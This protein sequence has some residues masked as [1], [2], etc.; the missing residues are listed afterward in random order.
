M[1]D[2]PTA[3]KHYSDLSVERLKGSE[4]ELTGDIPVE[5]ARTFVRKAI[6]AA[7]QTLELPG[8]RKG[9]VPEDMVRAHVGEMALLQDAAERALAA[10]YPEMVDEHKLEVVGRPAVTITKLVPGN[11]IGFKIKSALYPTVELPN[12]SKLAAQELKKHD[13]P[14]TVEIDDAEIAT[15]LERLQKML[16]QVPREGAADD[17][18]SIESG[19]QKE[20]ELPPLS[21]DFAK[22]LGDFKDLND[23]KEKIKVG[24]LN[25][26]K[27]KAHEK[28]RLA[29][30]DAIIAKSR[31]EVPEIF[32]EGELDQMLASFEERVTRAGMKFEEYLV[33]AKKTKEDLRNEWRAD[34]EKRAKLQLIFNEIAKKEKIEL[35]EKKLDRQVSHIKEHY[36]DAPESSVRSYVA[37][38]MMNERVF[39]LLEGKDA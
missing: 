2:E 23:L 1:T 5:T 35:D 4:V 39:R 13:D 36:T 7:Q 8:F 24:L 31:L 15:E 34:A 37:T 11:P 3:A 12:Y 21:D 20:P 29:L 22:Q 14:E 6:R 30:A 26:K 38:Q 18:T 25:D 19:E 10:A 16:V 32:I 33:E 28:R 9:R 27:Q 17:T